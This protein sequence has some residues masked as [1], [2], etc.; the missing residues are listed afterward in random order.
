MG[1]EKS[2]SDVEVD[3]DSVFSAPDCTKAEMTNQVKSVPVG[4]MVVPVQVETPNWSNI[5]SSKTLPLGG[6]Q[7]PLTNSLG[8]K[9]QF[10][11]YSPP[12]KINSPRSK[13]GLPQLKLF[14]SV[15]RSIIVP[16]PHSPHAGFIIARPHTIPNLTTSVSKNIIKNATLLGGS[17]FDQSLWIKLKLQQFSW[18]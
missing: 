7:V 3:N 18:I 12:L 11:P 16:S 17:L 8:K 9:L 2:G 13:P 15:Q 10:Y 14:I 4:P 6:T 5:D 1:D